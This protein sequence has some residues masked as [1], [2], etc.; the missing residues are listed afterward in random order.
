MPTRDLLLSRTLDGALSPF[1][2]IWAL[3]FA[4]LG[5]VIGSFINVVALRLPIG[6]SFVT[7][8]SRCPH[9]QHLIA[10]YDNI[11]LLSFALLRGRCRHCRGP[12]S[13]QYPAV[14]A[15]AAAIALGLWLTRGPSCALL[16][17][18]A[19]C[20][21]LLT[22]ALIDA[23]TFLL[24]EALTVPLIAVAAIGRA[25][26]PWLDNDAAWSEIRLALVDAAA[27]AAFG[28]LLFAMVRWL[29]TRMARSSGRIGPDE[30][31]LGFGD[32][33]LMAGIGAQVGLIGSVGVTFLGSVQGA[34]IGGLLLLWRGDSAGASSGDDDDWHPPPRAIPYG[35][36]LALAAVEWIFAGAWLEQQTFGLFARWLGGGS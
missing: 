8:R 11:P 33:V 4:L 21:L 2:V 24:P 12:I 30:E 26:V 18:G 15:I 17:D 27:G 35:P 19:V 29:G 16:V 25:L 7:P 14:E 23:R 5:A 32:L 22:L 10:W 31:A 3:W 36:F 34:L 9:C 1:F 20:G 13:W 28:F 6:I